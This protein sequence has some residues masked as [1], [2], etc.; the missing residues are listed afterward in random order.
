M[1]TPNP[2]LSQ[3]SY[4]FFFAV[5]I[6]STT[7]MNL[8]LT[9][10]SGLA[11]FWE[12]LGVVA[13]AVIIGLMLYGLTLHQVYRYFKMYPKDLPCHKTFSSCGSRLA[14]RNRKATHAQPFKSA[15]ETWHTILWLVA[16]YVARVPPICRVL[17]PKLRQRLLAITISC[18]YVSQTYHEWRDTG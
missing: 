12:T 9:A 5:Y 10:Q 11:A 18:K 1:S 2:P 15:L 7:Q 8:P 6:I 13:L 16:G 17:L 3:A 14:P 4:I